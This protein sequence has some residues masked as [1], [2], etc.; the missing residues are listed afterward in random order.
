MATNRDFFKAEDLKLESEF[1]LAI[2]NTLKE[3]FLERR[4]FR[5]SWSDSP[6]EL[7]DEYRQN[8]EGFLTVVRCFARYVAT[9]EN[10]PGSLPAPEL[11]FAYGATPKTLYG[12]ALQDG[13]IELNI[14]YG[15]LPFSGYFSF[16]IDKSISQTHLRWSP[17]N[18]AVAYS[19]PVRDGGIKPFWL[20]TFVRTERIDPFDCYRGFDTLES[21]MEHLLGLLPNC[22]GKNFNILIE[23]NPKDE[24]RYSDAIRIDPFVTNGRCRHVCGSDKETAKEIKDRFY[25]LDQRSE[26]PL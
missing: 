5:S 4:L 10:N 8:L 1:E 7:Q 22:K 20:E 26:S 3:P 11:G 24:F 6:S 18:G 12:T 25:S 13:Y 23:W 16:R 19:P 14:D 2:A 17:K 9:F 15:F 21:L